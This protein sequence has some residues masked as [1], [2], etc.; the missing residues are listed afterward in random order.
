[1]VEGCGVLEAQSTNSS[2]SSRYTRHESHSSELFHQR[3]DAFEDL[4]KTHL[5]HHKAADFLEQAELLL[6]ALETLFQV[7]GFRHV[8][9]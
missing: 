8:L 4:L 6:R 7:L 1:M 3:Y 2:L 5:A 9:L